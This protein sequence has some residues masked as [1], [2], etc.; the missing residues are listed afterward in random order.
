MAMLDAR[1]IEGRRAQTRT[2]P[3]PDGNSTA[4]LADEIEARP[5]QAASPAPFA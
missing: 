4:A 5:M 1:A 2:G 3:G